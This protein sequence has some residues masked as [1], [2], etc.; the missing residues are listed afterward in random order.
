MSLLSLSGAVGCGV[1]PSL[2]SSLDEVMTPALQRQAQQEDNGLSLNGLSLNGL[3]LNGLSLNGLGSV[4]FAD[5][6]NGNVTGHDALMS[7]MVRC[8]A[9]A[10]QT[11]VFRNP[12]T[13]RVHTWVGSLGLAPNWASGKSATEPEEQVISACLLAHVNNYGLHVPISVLGVNA[14]GDSIDFSS[15]ELQAYPQQES[16]FFGN[17]FSSQHSPNPVLL[18][19]NDRGSLDPTQ[20]TLRPCGLLGNDARVSHPACLEIKRV[21]QCEK[22][23]TLAPGGSYYTSCTYNGRTYLP[24]TTRIRPADVKYCGDGKCDPG[25]RPG[26]DFTADSCSLD[27]GGGTP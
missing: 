6:F 16:C 5:W 15:E 26:P 25:E 20:S 24:I 14:S 13:G 21:G 4:A 19:G 7:Y 2:E 18:A 23:C 11:H 3:S 1:D 12:D 22:Y 8:A 27:C 17:I 9:P 10:G